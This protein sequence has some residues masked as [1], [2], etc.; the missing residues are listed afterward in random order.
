MWLVCIVKALSECGLT[1]L[2]GGMWSIHPAQTTTASAPLPRS[3][4]WLHCNR[5]RCASDTCVLASKRLSIGCRTGQSCT[6]RHSPHIHFNGSELCLKTSVWE[7]S[8]HLINT[9]VWSLKV[10]LPLF[11]NTSTRALR[12]QPPTGDYKIIC[13]LLGVLLQ[14]NFLL[15]FFDFRKWVC[16]T[17]CTV[18]AELGICF[19]M[20]CES[21]PRSGL[22]QSSFLSFLFLEKSQS[23]PKIM[24]LFETRTS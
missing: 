8:L 17:W 22:V 20:A 13:F 2:T 6:G 24:F 15:T 4:I 18:L 9:S 19:K 16:L 11:L 1:S 23:L 14:S 5:R 12:V 7:A 3:S 10:C 21:L